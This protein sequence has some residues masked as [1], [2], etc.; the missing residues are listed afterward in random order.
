M[1]IWISQDSVG[2]LEEQLES[3]KVKRKEKSRL[4]SEKPFRK[5]VCKECLQP[6]CQEKHP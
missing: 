4:L 5:K 6:I 1:F 3:C 2:E